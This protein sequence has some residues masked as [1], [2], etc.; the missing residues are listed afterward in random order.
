M[1]KVC[2]NQ[3]FTVNDY[4]PYRNCALRIVKRADRFTP[5]AELHSSTKM[6]LLSDRHHYHYVNQMYKVINGLTPEVISDKFS[7]TEHHCS[8]TALLEMIWQS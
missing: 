4:S 8:T 5:S 6:L 7:R 3:T 2:Y 1:N